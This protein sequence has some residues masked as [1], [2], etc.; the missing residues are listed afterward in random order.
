MMNFDVKTWSKITQIS[1]SVG[2]QMI[3]NSERIPNYPFQP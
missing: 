2:I 1:S 3:D